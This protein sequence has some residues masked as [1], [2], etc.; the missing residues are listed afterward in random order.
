MT[1][2]SGPTSSAPPGPPSSS[3]ETPLQATVVAELGVLVFQVALEQW[4]A[5]TGERPMEDTVDEVFAAL[6]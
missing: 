5:G 2:A 3:G 1:P 4:A 6:P